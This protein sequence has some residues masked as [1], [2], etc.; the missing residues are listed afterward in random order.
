MGNDI[1]REMTD[2]ELLREYQ[3][4]G[5]E[6]A[7][8]ALVQRHVNLVYSAAFRHVRSRELAEEITQSV[9]VDLAQ[10]GRKLKANSILS[11]WLYQVARARAIDVFRRESRRQVREQM[12]VEVTD[13]NHDSNLWSQIE[14]LFEEA[15]RKLNEGERTAIVLRYFENKS[16]REVGKELGT[17]EDTVQ[18][19]IS[20]AVE[21]LRN[22]FSLRGIRTPAA[23][24]VAVISAN[25]VQ[26]APLGLNA[27]S[28]AS[29]AL[30]SPGF[31]SGTFLGI[32]KGIAMT[33]T[34]K[35]IVITT[36]TLAIGTS[37]FE[38]R[39]A[40]KAQSDLASLRQERAIPANFMAEMDELRESVSSGSN[41]LN[42]LRKENEE[43]RRQ[44]SEILRLRGEVALLRQ[45]AAEKT[46]PL[47][48]AMQSW[49]SRV[50]QLRQRFET[51]PDQK[52][53]EFQLLNDDDWL[54]A[55]KTELAT[56]EDYRRAM[57]RLRSIAE[58]KLA[59][60]L[61]TGLRKYRLANSQKELEDL[62][63]L[64]PF[65]ENPIDEKIL[66]RYSIFPPNIIPSVRV[67]GDWVI[68]QKAP[69]DA[70]YDM[71]LVLG[72]TGGRGA[73]P[74]KGEKRLP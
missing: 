72:A 3:E 40:S 47:N 16:L 55:A 31:C 18:K 7:F 17:N 66:Q 65:L 33:T 74:F 38:A 60:M 59:E 46:S 27:V 70:E 57:S 64:Q 51:L 1:L 36:I 67:G 42:V 63:D 28:L 10:K 54:T 61:Q 8:T 20:R 53:P 52:I 69:V 4:H 49:L 45:N 43:L 29:V 13:M 23:A 37:V 15:M 24:L 73:A 14:P 68:S 34:Q 25:A 50:D 62:T 19:R 56:E 6:T 12:A 39:R 35:A 71:R 30:A 5:S 9:F 22:Y 58:N 41:R 48:I 32:A 26:S 44:A 21:K 2:L 11:A